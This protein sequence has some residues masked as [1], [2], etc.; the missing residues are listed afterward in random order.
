MITIN[1]KIAKYIYN[2]FGLDTKIGIQHH[3]YNGAGAKAYPENKEIIF[4][5]CMIIN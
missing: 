1:Q 3:F 2:L 5:F 4:Q